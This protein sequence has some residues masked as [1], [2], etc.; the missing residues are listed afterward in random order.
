MKKN[1][2]YYL[3]LIFAFLLVVGMFIGSQLSI[4][5]T[6]SFWK[7]NTSSNKLK[8]V[9]NLIENDYVDVVDPQMLEEIAI[10]E[11]LYSLDPHSAY[12][13][14]SNVEEMNESIKGNFKGIGVMFHIF[15]DTVC[16]INV[17]ENSPA[18]KVGLRF[19]DRIVKVDDSL[20]A[21]NGITNERITSL[22]KGKEGSKVNVNIIRSTEDT[23][24]NVLI[25]RAL[26]PTKSVE[27]AYLL[28]QK[29]VYIKLNVFAENT[30]KEFKEALER[31]SIHSRSNLIID[32]RGNGGGMM[33]AALDVIDE[34]LPDKLLIVET[35]GAHM[36]PTKYYSSSKGIFKKGK[37]MILVDERTASASEILAGAVQDNDRGTVIGVRTFGKGLVQKPIVLS[38]GSEIRL[39][40]SR[41]YTPTGR[42]IQRSYENGT[43]D[44]YNQYVDRVLYGNDSVIQY[45]DS[46]KYVTKGGRIVYGG[47]GILPDSIVKQQSTNNEYLSSLLS[48]NIIYEY[49]FYYLDNHYASIKKYNSK[50]DFI[51]NF[52]IDKR[53]MNDFIKFAERK[54]VELT[55]DYK[56][57]DYYIKTLIKSY[58]ARNMYGS[59]SFYRI[60]N[61]QDPV[62]I[63]ANQIL[64]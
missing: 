49:A 58:I 31:L 19:G 55:K 26:I 5:N 61:T 53:K 11:M 51:S 6:S 43:D 24:F 47:G 2:N 50:K 30:H 36:S 22:L 27:V 21:G 56:E 44:Y 20:V 7:M 1:R 32:L 10:E 62:M 13:P 42:C 57:E 52:N 59:E 45:P 3:P 28:N 38:D 25:T 54:G 9:I 39:T 18:E 12:I 41:Y 34:L 14:F 16:V 8:D 17:L 33:Q 63:K 40:I 46:L 48:N 4:S 64:E 29:T 23:S 37:L 60:W 15:Q 35:K